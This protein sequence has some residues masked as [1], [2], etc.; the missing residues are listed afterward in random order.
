MSIET[1]ER[2]LAGA[3]V[4]AT[5]CRLSAEGA[6]WRVVVETWRR[7][8]EWLGRLVFAPDGIVV[9]RGDVREGPALLRGRSHAEVVASA[10]E[11]PEQRLRVLLHSLV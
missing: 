8:E 1:L 11:I 7:G 4:A 5:L 10:H 9:E 2:D 6:Y 3:S